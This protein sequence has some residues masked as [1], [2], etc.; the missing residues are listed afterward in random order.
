MG[1]THTDTQLT[2]PEA[3]SKA[4]R[5]E[6]LGLIVLI[7]PTALVSLDVSVLFLA[8]PHLAGDLQATGTQ[9]LWI[10]DVY[11]FMVAGFLITMGTLGDRIGRRRLLLI[12]AAAFGA[13]SLAGA[14]ATSSEMLILARA[15]LG[16]AG[17]TLA[18][19]TLALISNMFHDAK[20]RGRA[21]GMWATCMFGGAA[22]GPVVG[23]L[24]LERFWWGSVFLLGA[25]VAVVL[26]ALGPVLLPEYRDPEPGRFDLVS[27]ALSL[28]AILPIVYGVK[29]LAVHGVSA[30]P[31]AVPLVGAAFGALFVRRQLRME[32]PLLDLRLFAS[33][34]FRAALIGMVVGGA[35]LAG[36]TLFTS[37]YLQ[38]VLGLP[39][40]LA[41]LAQVPAALGIAV[42]VHL[43]PRLVRRHSA[44]TAILLG[45][46]L[47]AAAFAALAFTG[48]GGLAL[49]VV[50]TGVAAFGIGPIFVLGTQLVVGS[51]PPARAGAAA[52]IAET[53]NEL[54]ANLG[55]AILGSLGSA[56]YVAGF[57]GVSGVPAG[58][59]DSAKETIGAAGATAATLADGPAAAL[60]HAANEAFTNGL[61]AVAGAAAL[62]TA[63]LA[64]FIGRA[65]GRE[66]NLG[67]G[68]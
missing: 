13:A 37:Q 23:G 54:G 38:S 19:S 60:V 20:E 65:V 31:V 4:G 8:L 1:M 6:W 43:A 57:G 66:K 58:A 21:I 63:V 15:A 50:G 68:S 16:I 14:F 25:P 56:V 3:P 53:G 5:R 47:S 41:G 33:R 34:T 51:V 55:F 29:E 46:A 11:G 39:P 26:L 45:L 59:V 67:E 62:V 12:G 27:V 64:V 52:S 48:T 36:T 42:G 44:R 30:V 61:S 49:I 2:A 18:P 22:L 35:C 9:Q 17:A 32:R 7:F 10:T 40:A 28:V 24:L